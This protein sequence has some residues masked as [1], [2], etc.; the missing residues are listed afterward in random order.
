MDRP[1]I[2]TK[3]YQLKVFNMI[4]FHAETNALCNGK[5]IWKDFNGNIEVSNELIARN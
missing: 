2:S 3:D 4:D 5:K 1:L